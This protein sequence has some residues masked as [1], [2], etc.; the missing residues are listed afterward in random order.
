MGGERRNGAELAE[1]AD[2]RGNTHAGAMDRRVRGGSPHQYAVSGG[3]MRRKDGV[4][5]RQMC[6]ADAG[7]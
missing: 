1:E 3:W 5:V 6:D 7:C 2:D 4:G